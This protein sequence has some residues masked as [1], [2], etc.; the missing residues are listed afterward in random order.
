MSEVLDN[1][2]YLLR[3]AAIYELNGLLA[4]LYVLWEHGAALVAATGC[5]YLLFHAPGVQ[6]PWITGMTLLVVIAAFLT[7]A[8]VPF[9]VAGMAL[10]GAGAV[11]LDRFNPDLL[12]WRVVGAL[13]IYA[14]AALAY[15]AYG[16][17]LTGIDAAAWASAIGGQAEA[18]ATLSQGRS[19]LNTLATWGLW[20]ILPLGYLSLLVQGVLAH[21]PVAVRP[22]DM[23]T[24]VRTRRGADQG[25]G[26][27]DYSSHR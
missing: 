24:S 2:Q 21:P 10:I 13:A 4:L 16:T 8:P 11:K 25:L 3:T 17:Y 12:R 18:Q 7:P 19:F 23:I 26:L 6:R 9:L 5:L 14:A 20:L 15:L 27:Y 22:A 1:L